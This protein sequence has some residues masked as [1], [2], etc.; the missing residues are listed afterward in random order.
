M[1]KQVDDKQPLVHLTV[2]RCR[3]GVRVKSC[4]RAGFVKKL[5]GLNIKAENTN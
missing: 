1:N 3:G 4:L 5:D 2:K